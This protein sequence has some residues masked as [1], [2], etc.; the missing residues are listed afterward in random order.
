MVGL[1]SKAT[2]GAFIRHW[3]H[4]THAPRVIFSL[5]PGP[6]HGE[7]LR[8]L[9]HLADAAAHAPGARAQA[10]PSGGGARAQARARGARALARRLAAL[11][12]QQP[13]APLIDRHCS[14]RAAPR[15]A[16]AAHADAEENT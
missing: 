9:A 8:G 11:P 16:L 6:S 15:A 13:A 5:K 10:A 3:G 7:G 12:C 2:L 4:L 14:R 1:L